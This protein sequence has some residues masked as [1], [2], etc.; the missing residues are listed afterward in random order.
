MKARSARST[1]WLPA[2]LVVGL[3]LMPL[4]AAAFH[5]ATVHLE[6]GGWFPNL[7]AEARSS[8]FG[9]AGDLITNGDLGLEDPDV[10][11]MGAVTFRLAQRHTI[12]I[13]GFGFNVDGSRQTDKTFTFDGRTYPVSTPITSEADVVFAGADYG[14]DL[15][16]APPGALGLTFG[17]RYVSARA[18]IRAPVLN[19]EGEG[20]LQTAL[21]AIGLVGVLHPFPVPPFASLALTARVT[22]GTIGDRGS[23]IDVDG[24]IEWL[25]IPV[26]AIRVGYRYFHGEGEDGG[27]EAKVDLS[28]PYASLTIAF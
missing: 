3:A 4:P 19:Q 13:E 17:A 24:G 15:V 25:P 2:A 9:V 12:R 21:P 28:G 8:S 16:H 6:A 10:V 7:D 26:L 14:F 11:I 5:D 22:G 20:E 1:R 23:F 27:D 18:K